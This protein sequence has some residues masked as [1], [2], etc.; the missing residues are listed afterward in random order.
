MQLAGWLF[1][2]CLSS[3]CIQPRTPY[4]G[5]GATYSGLGPPTSIK[6]IRSRQSLEDQPDK[7]KYSMKTPFVMVSGCV[8]LIVNAHYDRKKERACSL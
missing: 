8:K 4:S 2:L 5:N 6:T 7:D 3:F 1:G